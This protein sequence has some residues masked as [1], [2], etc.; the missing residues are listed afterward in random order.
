MKITRKL[1]WIAVL[2]AVMLIIALAAACDSGDDDDDTDDDVADDDTADDDD[3]AGDDDSDDDADP[4]PGCDTLQ[5]GWNT[6]FMVDGIERSFYIDLPNGVEESWPW[7]VVFNWHGYG[8]TAT[9]MRRLVSG[10]VNNV[11]MPFIAV[12]PENS[13]GMIFD[14]DLFDASN[15]ANREVR[16]FDD[17]LAQIDKCWGVDYD[18]VHT[19]GFSFGDAVSC[20]LMVTRGD[21]IAS[22]GG[23]SGVYA[24]NSANTIMYA[25]SN[26]P[27]LTTTNQ[28]AE[29][30]IHG[31]IMDI[32]VLPFG[33]YAENDRQYLNARG[34][35]VIICNHGSL[36]NM[37][38]SKM[39]S[40]TIIEFFA[41]HPLGTY[42]SPYAAGLPADYPAFC[43]F[44]PK[45]P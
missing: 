20:M 25:M 30:R 22:T 15:P 38:P 31:G 34:H 39:S 16:L 5:A 4:P 19:M 11:A 28:Y 2:A 26:W 14:W 17:L 1:C 7:P 8:D 6:G 45:T 23:Y 40:S 3:A 12:T 32:N 24:S 42:S 33:K 21:V 41:D 9:N 36:H 37:G 35:D 18:H 29:L 10:Q 43:E 13:K 44:S 27:E